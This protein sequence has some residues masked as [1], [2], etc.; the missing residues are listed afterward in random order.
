[1]IFLSVYNKNISYR[2]DSLFF[3]Y[4]YFALLG[5]FL[6]ASLFNRMINKL[7][8]K[9]LIKSR[10]YILQVFP[11][12]NIAFIIIREEFCKIINISLYF[13]IHLI[14]CKLFILWN[15]DWLDILQF[16]HLFLILFATFTFFFPLKT[17]LK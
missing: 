2:F 11:W 14:C 4:F 1:M 6:L 8:S 10:E 9:F 17:S 3:R 13:W 7:F 5:Y 15:Q 16:E 12:W